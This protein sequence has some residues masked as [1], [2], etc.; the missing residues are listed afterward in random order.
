[1]QPGIIAGDEVKLN[2]SPDAILSSALSP[3]IVP[4]D[5]AMLM[6]PAG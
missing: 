5:L 6:G 1:M 3:L 4:D 2:L